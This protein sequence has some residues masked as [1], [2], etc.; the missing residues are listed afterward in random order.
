MNKLQEEQLKAIA[1]NCRQ[2]R[3]NRRISQRQI[4]EWCKCSD[5][6]ISQFEKGKNDSITILLGYASVLGVSPQYLLDYDR[7]NLWQKLK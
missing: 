7:S 5:V 3:L 2:K 4:A 1:A 6:T